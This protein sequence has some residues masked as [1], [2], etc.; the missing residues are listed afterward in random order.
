MPLRA[1]DEVVPGA[2]L[3]RTAGPGIAW[4]GSGAQ[5][6]PSRM[7]VSYPVSTVEEAR[8]AVDDYVA[9]KPAF[10]KIWV[11]DRGGTKK[12]L[13]PPLYRAVAD[14]AH[15]YNVPVGVHNVTLANAK[16]LMRAGVEGWLHVP[17]RGGEVADEELVGIVKD[18]I[19]RNDRPNIW[20]TPSSITAWMDTQGGT[21]PEWLDDPLLRAVYSA[22]DIEKHWGDPLKKRTPEDVARA[23][24]GFDVRR[25]QRDEAEGRR[26]FASSTAP[27]RAR[28]ASGSATSTTSI[29][30]RWW[31]WA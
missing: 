1:R 6:D 11:D 25:P 23:R 15:K 13:T 21:R 31:R 28:A 16:E 24:R 27:T 10:I 17:A 26:R 4:P 7:D 2:A 30:R 5:G 3:F 9:M 29:S 22:R 20:M 14:E 19:A 12:T 18:R 8:A